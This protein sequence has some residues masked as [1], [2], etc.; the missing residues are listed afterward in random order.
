MGTTKPFGGLHVL[1]IGDFFQMALV[2]DSY[3]FKDDHIN[4]GP[5]AINLWTTHF[6]IFSLTE[7]MQQQGEK[8]FCEIFNRLQIGELTENDQAILNA[9][10]IKR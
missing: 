7:I 9:Q 2:M 6:Y 1:A 5:L 10:K 8:Q 3:I 4:Y